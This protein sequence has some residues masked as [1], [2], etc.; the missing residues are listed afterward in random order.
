V[1]PTGKEAPRKEKGEEKENAAWQ[2]TYVGTRGG[3]KKRKIM[4]ECVRSNTGHKPIRLLADDPAV[5][6]CQKSGFNGE[7]DRKKPD[8]TGPIGMDN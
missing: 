6:G 4:M 3:S 8:K 1:A 5:S 7:E 2:R